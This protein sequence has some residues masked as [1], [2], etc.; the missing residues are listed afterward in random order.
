MF[1]IGGYKK[2]TCEI[3]DS[4][5]RK[6]SYIKT[7]SDFTND[8]C[9]FQAVCIDNRI[10]VFRENYGK[11]QTKVFTYNYK[12]CEWKLIDCGVLKNKTGFGCVRYHE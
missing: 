12:T 3:F 9:Y 1:V 7:C 2:S 11:N 10:V 6:F 8:M 4:Y 5:S